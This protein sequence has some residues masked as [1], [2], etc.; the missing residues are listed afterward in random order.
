M[1]LTDITITIDGTE[2]TYKSYASRSEANHILGADPARRA[3]WLD[4]GLTDALKG[5]YLVAATERL[6]L[7]T[8]A[9][10]RTGG[11]AQTTAWPRTGLSDRD[12]FELSGATIPSGLERATA[13]L[14]GTIAST[15]QAAD[16]GS[17]SSNIA[18][19]G[20]GS[21]TIKF[22]RNQT[23][24]VG[25]PLQDETAYALVRIWLRGASRSFAPQTFGVDGDSLFDERERY[26]FTSLL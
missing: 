3:V 24:V 16:H 14:A 12:G 8:W 2:M 7:L 11:A 6:D 21:A 17:S 23:T 15:P 25:R 22:F 5:V 1:S 18:E 9:G 10:E 4:D 19:V 20:A 13:L 26:G